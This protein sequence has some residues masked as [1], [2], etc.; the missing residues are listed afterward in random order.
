MH[1]FSN[2][3]LALIFKLKNIDKL[4]LKDLHKILT[5]TFLEFFFEESLKYTILGADKSSNSSSVSSHAGDDVSNAKVNSNFLETSLKSIHSSE[6]GW[7]HF[8][9]SVGDKFQDLDEVCLENTANIAKT[10]L[11][12]D[13]RGAMAVYRPG[14]T[15]VFDSPGK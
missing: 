7:K 13:E 2:V 11:K 10:F 14:C 8:E 1:C 3:L 9:D 12:S 4:L 15:T 5:K 6:V